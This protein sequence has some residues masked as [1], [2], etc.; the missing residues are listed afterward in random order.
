MQGG[1]DVIYLGGSSSVFAA[2]GHC[3]H[4]SVRIWDTLSPL[5]SACV[6]HLDYHD[7]HGGCTSLT[8]LPGGLLLASG[9]ETGHVA[10]HDLR[11]LGGSA[12]GRLLW[13]AK[14]GS[15]GGG[16]YGRVM[17]AVSGLRPGAPRTSSA[18]EA[19]M[20]VTGGKD[21]TVRLW[22]GSNGKSLQVRGRPTIRGAYQGLL[23]WSVLCEGYA[24]FGSMCPSIRMLE[25]SS[26]V[27]FYPRR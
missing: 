23:T 12:G 14:H 7:S 22:N 5:H 20:L 18:S 1:T 17:C 10:V 8:M 25:S 24:R 27:R 3:S 9:G 19:A 4:G 26:V 13:H 15:P 16:H 21:G 11:M 6:G 2:S